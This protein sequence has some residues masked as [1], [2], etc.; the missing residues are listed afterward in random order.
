MDWTDYFSRKILDRGYYYIHNITYFKRHKNIID[1]EVSGSKLY[2]VHIDLNNISK[3]TCNCPY[4]QDGHYCKHLAATLY[5]ND[6]KEGKNHY[7]EDDCFDDEDDEF[8]DYF[9]EYDD[10]ND[11]G[12]YEDN[13]EFND[14]DFELTNLS[15]LNEIIN[16]TN[17]KD[18]KDFLKKIL[19]NNRNLYIEFIDTINTNNISL[20]LSYY[21]EKIKYI[22]SKQSYSKDKDSI[23]IETNKFIEE[24]INKLIQENRFNDAFQFI[25][26]IYIQI[27][28]SSDYNMIFA[29][30]KSAWY[31]IINNCKDKLFIQE[32][33]RWFINK[34]E[35]SCRHLELIEVVYDSF[36]DEKYLKQLLE[37]VNLEINRMISKSYFTSRSNL[38][39]MFKYKI[40]ISNKLKLD[41]TD[42]YKENWHNRYIQELYIN[43]CI[44]DCN[45]DKAINVLKQEQE[46]T[47]EIYLK[48]DYS[49][50]ILDICELSNNKELYLKELWNIVLNYEPGNLE[51]YR[52]LKACYDKKEWENKR[53]IVFHKVKDISRLEKIYYDENLD[54][55]LCNSVLS[56]NGLS[57]LMKYENY[58]EPKYTKEILEKYKKEI[59][60]KASISNNRKQYREIVQL[61]ERMLKFDG[62]IDIV[63]KLI[64]NF[65]VQYKKRP[66]MMQELSRIKL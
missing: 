46:K 6:A 36:I 66:S 14:N 17:E 27:C 49:Q 33:Y 8:N 1:A 32:M 19:K 5:E 39:K 4:F 51:Y 11:Y 22:F 21:Q 44:N 40:Q 65:K 64:L 23:S 47:N 10:A 59:Q 48:L 20:D 50:Q 54:E 38:E 30:C 41:L 7:D 52:D 9:N 28:L 43:Q 37:F 2:H 15:Q 53:Q 29:S 18:L 42:F 35:S 24:S 55:L 13:Y 26:N 31:K 56:T 12:E 57:H 3:M 63:K 16:N 45:Y 62:G 34:I 58:L 60:L 61:L 25:N